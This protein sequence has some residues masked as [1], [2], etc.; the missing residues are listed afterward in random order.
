MGLKIAVAVA[1]AVGV[2]GA[3][4]LLFGWLTALCWNHL[5][6]LEQL[7]HMSWWDGAVLNVLTSLLFK[8]TMS[9]SSS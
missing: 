9:V 4:A 5:P 2:L 7:H 3:I 8:N 6:F 1:G